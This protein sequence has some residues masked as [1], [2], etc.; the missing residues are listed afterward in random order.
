MVWDRYEPKVG[1][2]PW[3]IKEMSKEERSII[4]KRLRVGITHREEEYQA[5]IGYLH[6][7]YPDL[8][9]AN[10]QGMNLQWKYSPAKN[11]ASVTDTISGESFDMYAF[12]Y[13]DTERD[14]EPVAFG[15]SYW[16]KASPVEDNLGNVLPD[17]MMDENGKITV[18]FGY[19]LFVDPDYR[20]MGIADAQWVS[21]SQ[22]YR[23]CNVRFQ[24]EIQNEDS[25]KV[26][27]SM[28]DD[29]NKCIITSW[30]RLKNDGT[31]AGIRCLLDYTDKSLV[32]GFQCLPDN[33]KDFRNPF[34]WNFL[35]REH[36]TLEQL[37][38]PWNK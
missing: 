8:M 19:V 37:I 33:L 29:P 15:G 24:K 25:L 2:V 23:D 30:G 27:Q 5:I 6:M 20:R 11:K 17:Q 13:F 3:N 28:F 32:D 22:L 18:G 34:C 14:M 31:H 7:K 21:E 12:A 36:L 10:P 35:K 9:D 4:P 38:Q 16:K 26:T 1:K